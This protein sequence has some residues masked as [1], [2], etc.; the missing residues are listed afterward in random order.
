L[1][2]NTIVPNLF[3]TP[4]SRQK[5]EIIAPQTLPDPAQPHARQTHTR[6]EI[7]NAMRLARIAVEEYEASVLAPQS[8]ASPSRRQAHPATRFLRLA[9]FVQSCIFGQRRPGMRQP[10]APTPAASAPRA[11][12]IRQAPPAIARELPPNPETVGTAPE[13]VDAALIVRPVQSAPRRHQSRWHES[14]ARQKERSFLKKRTKKL[15]SVSAG[16]RA[17]PLRERRPPSG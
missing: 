13:N 1:T 14:K 10:A 11:K 15:L 2:L 7:E 3:P 16:I 17:S 12:P 4:E 5:R 8:A 6:A 9:S